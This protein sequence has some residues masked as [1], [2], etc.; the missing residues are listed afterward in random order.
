M[1]KNDL[2]FVF[3]EETREDTMLH[4]LCENGDK[5]KVR[6]LLENIPDKEVRK[7]YIQK[8]D[9][10]G[11]TVLHKACRNG[12]K[13]VVKLLI[14]NGA[15]VNMKDKNGQTVFMYACHA[16][17]PK[18]VIELLLKHGAEVN[19]R[20]NLGRTALMIACGSNVPE[21][22]IELL[23]N[24]GADVNMEDEDGQ[25]ALMVACQCASKE[26][27]EL[28]LKHG[29]E[30]DMQDKD[31]KTVLM[32]VCIR[33]APKEVIELLLDCGADVNM[34]DEDGQTALVYACA[35]N[36]PK[37]VVELLLNRGAE[38]NLEDKDGDTALIA[39]CVRNAPKEVVELL[40]NRGAE[41]NIKGKDGQTALIHACARNA[42]KEVIRILL[43]N[44]ADVNMRDKG[45]QTALVFACGNNASK[46]VIEL[47]LNRGAEVNTKGKEGFTALIAAC[48]RNAPKEVVEL[49]LK[50]GA[51]VN[52]K[53]NL[54]QTALM[55]ACGSNAPKEVI[56]LLLD[57]GADVNIKDK[58][59]QTVLMYACFMNAPKEVIE[60]LLDNGADVNMKDKGGQTALMLA[61][62]RKE[63]KEDVITLLIDRGA[64][65]KIKDVLGQTALIAACV[66][67]APKKVIELLL[68]NIPQ[69]DRLQY[70][71]E[72]NAKWG[73]TALYYA[74]KK[75]KEEIIEYLIDN[76][77]DMYKE[78]N[79]GRTP[80]SM[81]DIK[82]R[83]KMLK[84][85]VRRELRNACVK[86]DKGEIEKQLDKVGGILPKELLVELINLSN[87]D[88]LEVLVKRID[89][90][91]INDTFKLIT[92]EGKRNCIINSLYNKKDAIS[93]TS[94][95]LKSE[96]KS[97]LSEYII[98]E[99]MTEGKLKTI[100][101][102]IGNIK[103][104]ISVDI[105]N[106]VKDSNIPVLVDKFD[107]SQISEGF[108]NI[109]NDKREKI[110]ECLFERKNIL[111]EIKE[112][113]LKSMLEE[114]IIKE[115]KEAINEEKLTYI[116]ILKATGINSE[117]FYKEEKM[118]KLVHKV[119]KSKGTDFGFID[120]PKEDIFDEQELIDVIKSGERKNIHKLLRN[121]KV[122]VNV[123]DGKG[124]SALMYAIELKNNDT[125][126]NL[127]KNKDVNVNAVDNEKKSVLMYAIDNRSKEVIR[128][129]E[130]RGAKVDERT[131][132]Y[133]LKKG[134]DVS[135]LIDASI[136][137]M[138]ANVRESKAYEML[139]YACVGGYMGAIERLVNKVK[140]IDGKGQEKY[141]ALGIAFKRDNK[142]LMKY[143][144]RKGAS[145]A[146]TSEKIDYNKFYA[147]FESIK[148][149]IEAEKNVEVVK[150]SDVSKTHTK[151]VSK[152]RSKINNIERVKNGKKREN[153]TYGKSTGYVLSD[154]VTAGA[155]KS[156]LE[157][158][159][160][161][162]S[163]DTI[164][165]LLKMG[166]DVNVR[167]EDGRT[168]LMIACENKNATIIKEL[169]RIGAK[170]EIEDKKGMTALKI[171]E[172]KNDNLLMN[173]YLDA[174]ERRQ[175]G[176]AYKSSGLNL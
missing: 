168:P 113:T 50:R 61:C 57:N 162:I 91:L 68:E 128:C 154:A 137:S 142:D 42:P 92:K 124:K 31:G 6:K 156:L 127:L 3:L 36:A 116:K 25:T 134:K 35:G 5:E 30:V 132:M 85:L 84:A 119:K 34:E 112:G 105:I 126:K 164:L 28:L 72:K 117:I 39:A 8:E 33:N 100:L 40:L 106:K 110:V 54:E 43:D 65:V 121:N 123:V 69:K 18:E 10:Y 109:N 147:V 141:T 98:N 51:K 48:I 20:T 108:E 59:D 64:E 144:I 78:D 81:V 7:K 53:D 88:T 125:I 160:K 143:L 23:L 71:Q 47:L 171:L 60:L 148:S 75:G 55:G 158:C 17:A 89:V 135:E 38:V 70:V 107:I 101:R 58:N 62:L 73:R 169:I 79:K 77:A 111:K 56:E 157:E 151:P 176:Y 87:E 74:C 131:F 120:K 82:V 115:I 14:D 32:C 15:D 118:N 95:E 140:D 66:S 2:G 26:V 153:R 96:L 175:K 46:E 145:I 16:N 150:K 86:N 76:G 49:L 155:N 167:D 166:C 170:E 45:G 99:G 44:G 130:E 22:V 159:K 83:D 21:E 11:E 163:D 90:S 152:K 80:I 102:G 133:A 41:V 114:R 161:N 52:M 146:G 138:I 103:T 149:E 4:M 63:S 27:T 104:I 165:S 29:A 129:L 136:E 172:N 19:M 24:N 174:V 9:K 12:Y 97:K 173:I 67:N 94:G 122:N 139:T 1:K 93:K 13:E 37:E